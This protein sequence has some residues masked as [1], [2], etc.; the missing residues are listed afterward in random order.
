MVT[1]FFTS[2]QNEFLLILF[3]L[4]SLLIS[5]FSFPVIISISNDKNLVASPIE[6]SVHLIKT[7]TLGGVGIFIGFTI[8]ITLFGSIFENFNLINIIGAVIILFFLGLK[9]DILIISP[10]AKLLVQIIVSTFIVINN[11]IMVVDFFGLLG[12]NAIPENLAICFS[13]FVFIL[14]INAYNLIDGIDGLAGTVAVCFLIFCD[15]IFYTAQNFTLCILS[16][17]LLG[18]LLSFLYFN[19]SKNMKIFMGDTGSMI[20]GFLIAYLTINLLK[21]SNSN[22]F[23]FAFETNPIICLALLFYPL[24]DTLRVFFIRIIVYKK[25]PFAA[26]K[27]HIHHKLISMGLKH[28][29]ISLY[30]GTSTI[31]LATIA[32]LIN[33]LEIN[34]QLLIIIILGITLFS[35]PQLFST[36]KKKTS[37]LRKSSLL[38]LLLIALTNSSCSS[39]KEILY[40][41]SDRKD[42]FENNI[43]D[44]K[45]E[46]ND[47]LNI[48]INSIDIEASR[49][50]N[51]EMLENMPTNLQQDGI[52]L[53]GYLVNN[54]GEITLPVLG[55]IKVTDKT[56]SE[57]ERFLKR[58]LIDEEHLKDPNVIARIVNAKV[59]VLGEVK[60]PGTYSFSEKN[61]TLL[62][63]IGMAGDLTING[64]RNDVMLIRQDN[65]S[66]TI[67]KIDLTSNSWFD[68]DLYYIKQND[69]IVVNPNTAKI[70]SAGIIGNPS[71]I[72]S[73]I[74]ILLTSL[75]L[76][77]N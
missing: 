38:L 64:K 51:L 9:D 4:L 7:P 59:T 22:L 30:V 39:K 10:K 62:Q 49:I 23:N 69:V 33:S 31:I 45:I 16:S 54:E 53:K 19:F 46:I 25:S 44:Q 17:A 40:F 47:I 36:F 37:L 66:K 13:V 11:D 63:A 14:L 50:Y 18:S 52:K 56:V 74:S 43:I 77:K 68:S 5:F 29:E 34:K 3:F 58:K 20:V 35:L 2:F 57:L 72:I 71:T 26:D 15:I 67:H 24:V 70:K 8:S 6:R 55:Q 28:W 32:I 27:N 12:I 73:V 65:T 61:L 42:K 75:L 60:L 1:D 21:T 41:Q 48:R 76:L